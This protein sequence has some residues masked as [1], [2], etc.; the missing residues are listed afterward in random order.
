MSLVK[1]ATLC[2][3]C[4]KRSGEYQR[5][6]VCEGCLLD[7]CPECTHVIISDESMRITCKACAAYTTPAIA[8]DGLGCVRGLIVAFTTNVIFGLTGWVA[9]ELVKVVR[10]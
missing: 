5:F 8:D 10:L 6:A 7:V 3:S 1:F 2:D 4:G 9:Y